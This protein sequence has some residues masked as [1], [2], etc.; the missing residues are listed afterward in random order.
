MQQ[1]E[2]NEYLTNENLNELPT[3]IF[4]LPQFIRLLPINDK[5]KHFKFLCILNNLLLNPFDLSLV[6]TEEE[7]NLLVQFNI[8]A[9]EKNDL[10]ELSTQNLAVILNNLYI[11]KKE[12]HY[13][14][15]KIFNISV[16]EQIFYKILLNLSKLNKV[17]LKFELNLNESINLTCAK[18]EI[19]S[20]QAEK[21]YLDLTESINSVKDFLNTE[22]TKLGWIVSHSLFR[23]IQQANNP[24]DLL[25][26]LSDRINLKSSCFWI[27]FTNLLTVF[28]TKNV[29]IPF[30]FYKEML[31]YWKEDYKSELVR[32]SGLLFLDL[33]FK[34][35]I[36]NSL[37]EVFFIYLFDTSIRVKKLALKILNDNFKETDL[38][39]FLND[40]SFSKS[41]IKQKLEIMHK[42][43][44]NFPVKEYLILLLN[45]PNNELRNLS[46]KF[47][48]DYI[49]CINEITKIDDLFF[50]SGILFFIRH[51]ENNI[52]KHFCKTEAE[53][54]NNFFIDD[55][56]YNTKLYECISEEYFT[57]VNLFF[58]KDFFDHKKILKNLNFVLEKNFTGSCIPFLCEKILKVNEEYSDFLYNKLRRSRKE[59]YVLANTFNI[60]Y[61]SEILN[62]FSERINETTL[63]G[64]YLLKKYSNCF[65]E[66]A[67][68]G[69]IE[70]GLEY[71]EVDFT[72]DKGM[73]LR[74]STLKLINLINKDLFNKYFIRYFV[75]KSKFVRDF[76]IFN[77][78]S[79]KE[80]FYFIK[81]SFFE[82]ETSGLEDF[83][84]NY[85]KNYE[86]KKNNNLGNDLL[87]FDCAFECFNLLSNDLKKEFITGILSTYLNADTILKE[88]IFKKMLILKIELITILKE[89]IHK[90]KRFFNISFNF[91][92]DVLQNE[93]EPIYK[94][95]FKDDLIKNEFKSERANKILNE[96]YKN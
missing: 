75:D 96:I 85:Y 81:C 54:I 29:F 16:S 7:F 95:E 37:N 4:L 5:K 27:N 73:N 89:I 82:F 86:I 60:K 49:I 94:N 21:G 11:S 13:F 2:L 91:I 30:D 80:I 72:G 40:F 69:K 36:I 78:A 19:I 22:N 63:N 35:K 65:F 53:F 70:E 34:N 25:I 32:E 44:P 76:L 68:L 38:L 15:C 26:E 55:F 64:L 92:N 62:I 48:N 66:E 83:L 51:K 3:D 50:I 74:L 14:P 43:I 8:D 79:K 31:F 23:M 33:S 24:S 46:A 47:L 84:E 9:I 6:L 57:I 42:F 90:N 71:Y 20:Y 28:A 61:Q 88:F 41:T 93:R 87:H 67:L 39:Y 52:K 59:S 45:H 18:I 56:V 77:C 10:L 1:N 58:E 17:E 12:V